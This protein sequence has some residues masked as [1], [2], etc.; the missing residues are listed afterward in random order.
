MSYA[1]DVLGWGQF[2]IDALDEIIKDMELNSD[3][4]L[5]E[6]GNFGLDKFDIN[7]HFYAALYLAGVNYLEKVK[8]YC[9]DN[10]I[11]YVGTYLDYDYMDILNIYTNYLDSGYDNE[12]SD[13]ITPNPDE[14]NIKSTLE[15]FE[16]DLD[17]ENLELENNED[18]SF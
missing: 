7:S 17:R 11:N 6:V 1:K 12:I 18:I 5:D 14:E 9:D 10:D 8:E 16:I 4:V 13:L 2:D 3:D 15:I